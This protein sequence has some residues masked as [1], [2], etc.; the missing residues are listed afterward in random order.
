[1]EQGEQVIPLGHHFRQYNIHLWV[2]LWET[3]NT[4][5]QLAASRSQKN[6]TLSCIQLATDSFPKLLR[7]KYIMLLQGQCTVSLACP[8]KCVFASCVFTQVHSCLHVSILAFVCCVHPPRSPCRIAFFRSH[9]PYYT[10]ARN[11][12]DLHEY[13]CIC[14]SSSPLSFSRAHTQTGTSV[15]ANLPD[16][17]LMHFS[18]ASRSIV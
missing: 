1:M 9:F 11:Q 18:I 2:L 14:A 3:Y 8:S 17:P 7:Q 6:V 12:M 4:L 15:H 13:K 5:S 16:I 10:L